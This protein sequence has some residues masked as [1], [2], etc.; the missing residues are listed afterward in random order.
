MLQM[1]DE[2]VIEMGDGGLVRL[3]ELTARLGVGEKGIVRCPYNSV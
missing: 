3:P 2:A 1:F